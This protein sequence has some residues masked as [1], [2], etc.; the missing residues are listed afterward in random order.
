MFELLRKYRLRLA[1]GLLLVWGLLFL[2]VQLRH[3]RRSGAVEQTLLASSRPFQSAFAWAGS[4]TFAL[5]GLLVPPL[6]S[7]SDLEA[8]NRRLRAELVQLEEYRLENE[9]LKRLLDFTENQQTRGVA[10]RV[11]GA[12]A[13]SWFAT[14][15]IDKGSAQ[16]VKEGMAV[17]NDQGLVGRVVRCAPHSS[18]VLLVTDASSAVATL[19]ERTRTRG[20]ARGTGEGLTL[21]YVALPEDVEPGDVVVTSG[22]GGVF[23]KG[24]PLGTVTA[25][26][27]GGFGMFQSITVL[28][29]V[30]VTRLEEVLVVLEKRVAE[31]LPLEQAVPPAQEAPALP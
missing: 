1:I 10:A 13:T 22:L 23:P 31:E 18:R 8:E 19:V 14:A 11:I 21:D 15:T 25:V 24:L 7:G 29:A 20:V 28:P 2:T 16:G 5:A 3:H 30:D 26:T 12:D 4:E 17:V 27:R 9:R 6:R